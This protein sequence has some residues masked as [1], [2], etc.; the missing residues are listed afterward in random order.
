MRTRFIST[1][2]FNPAPI[3]TLDFHHFSPPHLPPSSVSNA[4]DIWSCFDAL[5]LHSCYSY[6]IEKLPI[7]TSLTK[8]L[9]DV[10]PEFIDVPIGELALGDSSGG[11]ACSSEPRH[12]LEIDASL[13][14]N[15]ILSDNPGINNPGYDMQL[16]QG[17]ATRF[18]D[19]EGIAGINIIHFEAPEIHS[20]CGMNDLHCQRMDGNI[21]SGIPEVAFEM[22]VPSLE[23]R[24]QDFREI[25]H[26]VYSVNSISTEKFQKQKVDLL[27]GY[28]I[29]REQLDSSSYSFPVFEIDEESLGITNDISVRDELKT[30]EN[31]EYETWVQENQVPSGYEELMDYKEFDLLMHLSNHCLAVQ[32]PRV[33]VICSSCEQEL[34]FI[35]GCEDSDICQILLFHQGVSWDAA[36][37]PMNIILFEEF[38]F[39]GMEL[40]N[41]IEVLH[42]LGKVFTIKGCGPMLSEGINFKSFDDLIVS[43]ELILVDDSFK[44]FPV[45]IISN[46][47]RNWSLHS[48][49]E[50]MFSV[51]EP[52]SSS[53]FD[54]LY[55]DWYVLEKDRCDMYSS[56]QRMLEGIDTYTIDSTLSKYDN[57]MLVFKFLLSSDCSNEPNFVGEKEIS[58]ILVERISVP[59]VCLSEVTQTMG[60]DKCSLEAN[61]K[62][63]SEIGAAKIQVP[64]DSVGKFAKIDNHLNQVECG[65]KTCKSSGWSIGWN[66]ASTAVFSAD[67]VP[68][69]AGSQLQQWNIK[70]LR[71]ELS[72]EFLILIENF[73]K[74]YMDILQSD[75]ILLKTLN[76][77][78]DF[79]GISCLRLKKE[80]IIGHIEKISAPGTSKALS[81]DNIIS[82]VALCAIKQMA[83]YL[84]YYGLHPSQLY[85]DK[86]LS[87]LQ[88]LNSKLSFLKIMVEDMSRKAEKEITR[89]HPSLSVIQEMLGS[90]FTEICEKVLIVADPIAWW[91]LKKLMNLMGLSYQELQ[92]CRENKD[93]VQEFSDAATVMFHSDCCL[94][95]HE[96]LSASFPFDK[97]GIILEYGGCHK[98]S[99]VCN[100]SVR[101]DGCPQLYFIKVE[102]EDWGA[103]KAFCEGVDMPK[104]PAFSEGGDPYITSV[105]NPSDSK[106]VEL[107][108]FIPVEGNCERSP[109]GAVVE[110]LD[111]FVKHSQPVSLGMESDQIDMNNTSSPGIVI[112]V[113]TRNFDK[114][115]IISRR[116]TYQ[117]ILALEKGGAHIVERDL[118]L[119]VDLVVGAA[120]CLAWYDL[121]NIGK[122]ASASD[123]AF[124]CLALCVENIAAST[125]TSLSYAFSSC[126]L[127]FEGEKNFLAGVVESSH[128]LYAAAA[129]LGIDF[130]IFFSYSSAMTDEIVLS[131]IRSVTKLTRGLYPTMPDSESLAE[132]FLTAF[133]SINPLS[134]QC[135][136]SSGSTLV[137]FLEWPPDRRMHFA[138]K[139]KIPDES[140]ALLD[141]LWRYGEREDS[142]S[143]MTDN[144]SSASYT[145][146]RFQPKSD[147]E[148]RKRKYIDDLPNIDVNINEFSQFEP[149]SVFPDA[150]LSPPRGCPPLN[151]WMPEN[152]DIEQFKNPGLSSEIKMLRQ[153]RNHEANM[154][155]DPSKFSFSGIDI[156]DVP[157]WKESKP[158]EAWN[159]SHFSGNRAVDMAKWKK[160]HWCNHMISGNLLDDLTGE[161]IDTDVCAAFGKDVPT[162]KSMNISRNEAEDN[163]ALGASRTVNRVSFGATSLASLPTPGDIDSKY[164][165][166]SPKS[167]IES[168]SRKLNTGGLGSYFNNS[169][170]LSKQP[171]GILHNDELQKTGVNSSYKPPEKMD[172]DHFGGTP[173]WN[174]IH[175][176][177]CQQPRES[178]WTIEFLNKIKE[179]SRKRQ[180][181]LPCGLSPPFGPSRNKS[182]ANKRKSPSILEYFKYQ[183]DG[184]SK[185][186]NNHKRQ[187]HSGKPTRFYNNQ[188][189]PD[190]VLPTWTPVDKRAKRTL[191]FTTMGSGGQSK[192]IWSN[193][194]SQPFRGCK[195]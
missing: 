11:T 174:A 195:Y 5:S 160:T 148:A 138:Q 4:E 178:P 59:S 134:A 71:V 115:M 129:S 131:S 78:H 24:M 91:P 137:E 14:K 183:R 47:Q 80:E 163:L 97:F 81:N 167:I 84:C 2:F 122:K 19:V 63:L 45:P 87:S 151:S 20:F 108:N 29:A 70:I 141:L 28:S 152:S 114:E 149:L 182:N 51:L 139:Y 109:K 74:S 21:I 89:F 66:T 46:S 55:L 88:C 162:L 125:L 31:I 18:S 170:F 16:V 177:G 132:S 146:D 64:V 142:K 126:I 155:V 165:A 189:A 32:Y 136:L 94:V 118:S 75:A 193:K 10:L 7:E 172:G 166:C 188:K 135:L 180:Q 171:K 95:S 181:S 164:N 53:A 105:L 35:S 30:F 65:V 26:A 82:M 8:F 43:N 93:G 124:S 69:C 98:L 130:Q 61:E 143:G 44:S 90:T 56:C 27:E 42:G 62:I 22:D 161:V 128:E 127:I 92:T 194:D 48:L 76:C 3:E 112:V 159:S 147:S 49:S 119:P 104:L 191:S 123:E 38:Q 73:R 133:P 23:L 58:Q 25:Q 103:P 12:S 39:T 116:S 144:S 184:I 187:K 6:D 72:H 117:K 79:D 150:R 17:K 169:E 96:Y 121:K 179:K 102:L 50:K 99:R 192:L 111:C 54:G 13:E 140:I 67:S 34:D 185:K 120:Q 175:S 176:S 173:L 113:N 57:R 101:Q 15:E 153:S 83:W 9:S 106:M 156:V 154:R 77:Y 158:V 110:G 100:I 41:F 33:E 168:S 36:N 190:S 37:H 145:S 52:E 86:L 60:N 157:M 1:D 186:S 85:I 107:L 68:A 40:Y